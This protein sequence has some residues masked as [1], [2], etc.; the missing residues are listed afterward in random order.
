MRIFE[1]VML[2]CF[3]ASWPIS[4]WKSYTSRTTKGKSVFFLVLIFTGYLSG[5]VYKIAAGFDYV[6]WFYILNALMVF[7]DILLYIR[8]RRIE[9]SA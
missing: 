5:L 1:M 7:T 2:L 6:S 3:G 9:K 8:N 4:V